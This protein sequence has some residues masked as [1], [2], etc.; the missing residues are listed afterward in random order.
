MR[1][2]GID[3]AAGKNDSLRRALSRIE[4][5]TEA[6]ERGLGFS[7]FGPGKVGQDSS[8]PPPLATFTV[9]GDAGN[10]TIEIQTPDTARGTMFH[11]LKSSQTVPFV[12]S[13]T[14]LVHGGPSPSA[15][16]VITLPGETRYFQLRSRYATSVFNQPQVSDVVAA[17][18]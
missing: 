17:G 15:H 10:F 3:A 18:M 11:E 14:I 5:W 7:P 9:T 2:P 1:I 4:E 12:A 8:G 16:V 6:M 13:T